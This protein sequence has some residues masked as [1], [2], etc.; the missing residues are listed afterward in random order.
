MNDSKYYGKSTI[1]LSQHTKETLVSMRKGGQTYDSQIRE[2]INLSLII[3]RPS[4]PSLIKGHVF[5]K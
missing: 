4:M 3:N 5:H 1:N 2:L